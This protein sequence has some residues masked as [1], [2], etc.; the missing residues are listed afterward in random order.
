M[1]IIGITMWQLDLPLKKPY[2][3]S[4][5]RLKFEKLD[6]T[7][8]RVDTDAN[9]AGWGEGCPW[10]ST[11]LPAHGPGIRAGIAT[12]APSLLGQDPRSLEAIN[13][14]M[15]MALPDHLYVKSAID[16]ACWDILGKVTGM[17][18]WRLLGGTNA[19][20]VAVNSSISTGTS[21]EMISLIRDAYSEGYRT[22]SAKI[23]GSDPTADI[24]RI[25]AIEAAL[26]PDE[27]VTYDVNRAWSPA[28]AL[29]VLNNV[30]PRGWIEQPCETLQQCAQ[31]A[32][33]VKQPIMLDECLHTF[34]DH[35][36]A[37]RLDA[38]EGVKVKPNRVGGLTKAR[39]VRDFGVS[40]GWQMHIEDV[41]G[42][43]LADTAAVH[44]ASSTPVA[45]RLACWLCHHHL[46]ADPV[47]G[48]GARNVNGFAAPPTAPGLGV[49]PDVAALG[50]PVSV[51]E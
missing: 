44:L 35:L 1:K 9:V 36:Q 21:D 16:M 30:S 41:G 27:K 3:L 43:A 29:Q 7:F 32:R 40:V 45:N 50:A 34:G 37:W 11:Y 23:G 49:E 4:G 10:G 13:R 19:D 39:Q 31:V 8:V 2:W 48:Q 15:D 20:L 12:L 18:L 25:Q 14:T 28:V 26:K 33:R 24:A 42:S 47:P 6:S 46:A 22:H 17:P 38:C 51:F 5:G